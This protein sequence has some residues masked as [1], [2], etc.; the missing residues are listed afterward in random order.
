MRDKSEND[1]M[2]YDLSNTDG[3][4]SW[5]AENYWKYLEVLERFDR[6][7]VRPNDDN[8][9]CVQEVFWIASEEP[10]V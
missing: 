7:A 10:N 4:N 8:E 2:E 5:T 1:E 6:V 9:E 3:V